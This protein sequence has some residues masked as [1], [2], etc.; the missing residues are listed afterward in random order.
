M[1]LLMAKTF[2][3]SEEIKP[4]QVVR[5]VPFPSVSLR[6]LGERLACKLGPPPDLLELS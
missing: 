4:W 2:M 3:V 6:N 5:Q 1:S